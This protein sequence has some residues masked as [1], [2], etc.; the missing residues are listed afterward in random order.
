MTIGVG[1][2]CGLYPKSGSRQLPYY[3]GACHARVNFRSDLGVD[4]QA[5]VTART[6]LSFHSVSDPS[7]LH[8]V[9]GCWGWPNKVEDLSWSSREV[10][11][12]NWLDIPLA[13][14]RV[15]PDGIAEVFTM[16]HPYSVMRSSGALYHPDAKPLMVPAGSSAQAAFLVYPESAG[17]SYG[18]LNNTPISLSVGEWVVVV[19]LI[20]NVRTVQQVFLLTVTPGA[21]LPLELSTMA[22][23]PRPGWWSQLLSRFV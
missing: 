22:S 18:L 9:E 16:T 20:G 7:I 11:P 6:M 15:G 5:L 19:E 17:V 1:P 10:R 23:P 12:G 21:G 14:K 8:R 2:L 4:P 13:A 3:H